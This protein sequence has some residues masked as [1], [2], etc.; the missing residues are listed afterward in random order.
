MGEGS[1]L[2][3]ILILGMVAAFLIFR[4]R[5]VLGRRTGH[6]RQRPPRFPA[7]GQQDKP[8]EPGEPEKVVHLPTQAAEAAEPEEGTLE[9]GLTQIRTADP[10]FDANAFVTGAQAAFQMIVEAFAKGDTGVL[11]PLL[12]DDLYDEFSES[13]RTR[14]ANGESLENQIRAIKSAGM[15]DVRVDGR[16]AF[17]VVKFV[18][19]QSMET[20]DRT[21]KVIDGNADEAVEMTDLWTF[22]RN[23]RS[24][25]PNWTLVETDSSN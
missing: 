8:G 10:T 2:I 18:T 20:R 16:T 12:S 5:N 3:E 6:E 7:R 1:T 22:A 24:N 23:M 15:L 14:L 13:I 25:D 19:D 9:H 21:G 17:I 4:L 11:R